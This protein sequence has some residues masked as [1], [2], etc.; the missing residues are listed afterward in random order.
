MAAALSFP[1]NHDATSM[2]SRHDESPTTSEAWRD[3]AWRRAL[4]QRLLA[5][6]DDH[7]RDLPW[8]GLR[9]PYPVWVSEI[10][11]Q[12]TQVAT[13][14]AYFERFL[15]RFPDVAALADADEQEVLR[16]WEGLG[17]YRCARS[18]HAAARKILAEHQGRFPLEFEE[19]KRLPGVGRYT[20]GAILSIAQ[21]QRLP[22]LEANTQRLYARLIALCD[23]PRKAASQR[24][25]WE[26]A[27]GV[28]P[29]KRVGDF[30]QALMELGSLL[31][32]PKS[33]K[34]LLCP[35]AALC[36]AKRAN[37]QQELPRAAPKKQYVEVADAAVV[38]AKGASLLL[39]QCGEREQWAGLWDFPRVRLD[40]DRPNLDE[41]I[42]QGVRELTG[43]PVTLGERFAQMRHAVT[44]YRIRLDCYH[45]RPESTGSPANSAR[46]IR[47]EQLAD[48]PLN[49]T[50]RKIVSRLD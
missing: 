34:C 13:V 9:D 14:V 50:G 47:R 28:L 17:Y 16:Y 31:C 41:Q 15:E 24:L 45:A 12:Q 21:D 26:F 38:I 27:E 46:W 39:R 42:R 3:A 25:L 4:R 8:R 48:L 1:L 20:A 29:R 2:T 18:M 10:M 19:A 49:T 11:L 35:V 36:Q 32:L 40:L 30:N 5:W 6:Y 43:I 44:R 33:P 22:I 7:Q 23:D 37:L